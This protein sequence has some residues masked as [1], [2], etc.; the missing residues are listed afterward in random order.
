MLVTI[1]LCAA[2]G[3]GAAQPW[4]V[5]DTA[6]FD[7]VRLLRGQDVLVEG[8]VIAAVGPHLDAPPDAM[9]VDG[10][11]RTLL[12]GLIDAHVHITKPDDLKTALAFGVTTEL[13]MFTSTTLATA[14][15]TEQ[16]AGGGLDQADLRSAGTL[17]T[18][19]GGHGTEY[20]LP[21]PTLTTPEEAQAFVDARIAEG[22]DYIKVIVDDGSA[23]GFSRPTLDR[24]TLCAV[25]TAAHAR[26]KLA[27]AHVAT[28][29]D[30][31][32]ALECGADGIE[33]VP[34]GELEPPLARLAAS[35]GVFVTPTL[36]V[37]SAHE[38][39]PGAAGRAAHSLSV[40]GVTILAGTDAPNP[41][42]EHG[43]GLHHELLLLVEAGLTPIQALA[44]A[45]ASPARVF[46]LTDRGRV[47]PGLRADLLLVEGDPTSDVGATRCIVAVWKR[48]VRIE[49]I[50]P[51]G[52]L[53]AT[54]CRRSLV[55]ASP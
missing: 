46:G 47:A 50:A 51:R 5:R 29:A 20:G 32:T 14:I 48:G 27:V 10:S 41:P 45:T 54:A 7:G 16:A 4:L 22:S 6:V 1:V 26:D 37:V 36:G 33:H 18:A 42:C 30:L 8:G 25:V 2:A 31:R 35:R 34:A 49:S 21:I 11:G 13:D 24:A 9:V 39:T 38:R 40:A 53:P 3:A 23:M 28:Q 43:A 15:K 12:P 52:E 17:V 44:A 19:P 55:P